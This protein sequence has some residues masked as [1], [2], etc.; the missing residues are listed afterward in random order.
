MISFTLPYVLCNKPLFQFCQNTQQSHCASTI[1]PVLALGTD[2]HWNI[3]DPHSQPIYL[4]ILVLV[5]CWL[6][7]VHPLADDLQSNSQWSDFCSERV[8]LLHF[9]LFLKVRLHGSLILHE[10]SDVYL[11]FFSMWVIWSF[12]LKI[13]WMCSLSL[14]CNIFLE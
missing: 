3:F 10:K 6:N 2:V 13:W 9:L 1:V 5:L 7:H 11:I 4:S 12:C 14:K 8:F